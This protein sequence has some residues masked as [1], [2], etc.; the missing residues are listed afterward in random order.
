MGVA[1]IKSVDGPQGAI[2]PPMYQIRHHGP[3]GGPTTVTVVDPLFVFW[4]GPPLG[5]HIQRICYFRYYHFTSFT[6]MP[7]ALPPPRPLGSGGAII[8]YFSF[9]TMNILLHY[10]HMRSWVKWYTPP[11]LGGAGVGAQPEVG[12]LNGV[13]RLDREDPRLI[14]IIDEVQYYHVQLTVR[15]VRFP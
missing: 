2:H 6:I 12:A 14:V 4:S 13:A 11:R 7:G 8:I 5:A 1:S 9:C 3:Q 15:R 10:I